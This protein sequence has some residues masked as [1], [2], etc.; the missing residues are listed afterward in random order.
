MADQSVVANGIKLVG[1]A[2]VTGASQMLEGQVVAGIASFAVGTLGA[3]LIAKASVP[4]A[5][6]TVVAVKAD[7]YM[8][9]I[10]HQGLVERLGALFRGETD[11]AS[12]TAP[13]TRSTAASRST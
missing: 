6:A 12:S 5:V 13:A 1:E 7:S 10:D 9:S 11:T 3:A 8:R 2:L 4:V